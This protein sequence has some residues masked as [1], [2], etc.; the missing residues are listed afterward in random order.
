MPSYAKGVSFSGVHKST[1]MYSV[2]MNL[3]KFQ[4]DPALTEI[5][6]DERVLNKRENQVISRCEVTGISPEDF[7]QCRKIRQL[8]A[9]I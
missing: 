4:L 9:W 1:L 2:G 3:P 8:L 6:V 5:Y 7:N